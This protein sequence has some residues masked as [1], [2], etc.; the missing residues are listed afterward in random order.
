LLNAV[1]EN[2]VFFNLKQEKIVA[3]SLDA[4]SLI[5]NAFFKDL[6]TE[7]KRVAC[8]KIFER[9]KTTDDWIFA[10]AMLFNIDIMEKKLEFLAKGDIKTARELGR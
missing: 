7:M 6:I 8:V 2:E 9:A 4:D 5:N 3:Y 1:T 10:R